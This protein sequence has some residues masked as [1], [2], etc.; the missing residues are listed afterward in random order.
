[1]KKLDQNFSYHDKGSR[2]NPLRVQ[3]GALRRFQREHPFGPT[4]RE[5]KIVK[6][7]ANK[8]A[9]SAQNTDENKWFR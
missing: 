8:K 5:Q 6:I 1:L 9:L 2:E 4:P 7:T 3:G